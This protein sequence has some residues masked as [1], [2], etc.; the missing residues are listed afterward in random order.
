MIVIGLLP[1]LTLFALNYSAGI[2]IST[3]MN[4]RQQLEAEALRAEPK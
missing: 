2:R 1:V 4:V 3:H